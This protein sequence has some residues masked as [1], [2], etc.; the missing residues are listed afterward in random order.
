MVDNSR[1]WS[2]ISNLL[3]GYWINYT[4]FKRYDEL[5]ISNL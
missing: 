3:L 2:N 5:F 4:C 1:I